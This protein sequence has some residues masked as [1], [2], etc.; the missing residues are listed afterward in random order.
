MERSNRTSQERKK[1]EAKRKNDTLPWRAS[2]TLEHHSS[3]FYIFCNIDY[4]DNP[5]DQDLTIS[6]PLI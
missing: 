1:Q 2:D 6:S 5:I 3:T 4:I